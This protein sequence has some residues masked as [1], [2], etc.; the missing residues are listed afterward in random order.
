MREP[1]LP[2]GYSQIF[3]SYVFGPSGFWTMAPLHCAAKLDPFLAQSKERKGS[4]FAIWQPCSPPPSPSRRPYLDA[5]KINFSLSFPVL[6]SASAAAEPLRKATSEIAL[7]LNRE[8]FRVMFPIRAPLTKEFGSFKV[9]NPLQ[10][11]YTAFVQPAEISSVNL[12][13]NSVL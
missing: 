10:S 3:R 4:N 8:Y 13:N 7:I 6:D 12:G 2:G 1:W 5:R 11:I 9:G